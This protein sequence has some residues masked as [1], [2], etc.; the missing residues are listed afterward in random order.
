VL[1]DESGKT[2]RK[3]L[4]PASDLGA[5][6]GS[7]YR[8][9][10]AERVDESAALAAARAYDGNAVIAAETGRARKMERDIADMRHRFVDGPVLIVPAAN[11]FNF[12]FDPNGVVALNESSVV[13]RPL[14]ASDRWVSSRPA[15]H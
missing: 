10:A 8:V 14:H 1:L 12:G 4:S 9:T 3:T 7:A 2:W 5:L 11:N 13:Y 15:P 6:L